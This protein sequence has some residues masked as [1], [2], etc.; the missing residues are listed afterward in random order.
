MILAMIQCLRCGYEWEPKKDK[1][2]KCAHCQNPNYDKPRTRLR[3]GLKVIEQRSTWNNRPEVIEIDERRRKA[4][5]L[6]E[7]LNA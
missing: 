3:R 6:L 7:K 1:P 2:K 5:E 4:L